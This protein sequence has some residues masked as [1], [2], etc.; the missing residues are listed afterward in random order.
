LERV[1]DGVRGGVGGAGSTVKAAPRGAALHNELGRMVEGRL[2]G[3][4]GLREWSGLAGAQQCCAPTWMCLWG[5]GLVGLGD[6]ADEALRW[7][8]IGWWV[9]GR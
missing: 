7:G 8:V 5:K 6:G 1:W 4:R 2:L 9:I 3:E